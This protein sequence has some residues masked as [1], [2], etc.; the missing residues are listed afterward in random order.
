M[1]NETSFTLTYRMSQTYSFELFR[2]KERD[3]PIEVLE[4]TSPVVTFGWEPK[5]HRFCLVH[6]EPPRVD[7][8]FYTMQKEGKA[9][10]QLLKTLEK[11]PV[12]EIYWSPAGHN[13]VLAGMKTLNG[14]L[15]FYNADDHEILGEDE[16]F[17][18]TD[19]VWD[20]TGRFVATYVSAFRQP[21][22]NGYVIWNFAGK[23]Q[24]RVA[25]DKFF[26]FLWRPRPPS[27]LTPA[28][29]KEIRRKLPEYSAKY[30]EE[31]RAARELAATVLILSPTP[32]TRN[33]KPFTPTPRP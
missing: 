15:L 18:C 7:C 27:L 8:S 17:M 28:Q 22:E 31:D 1:A 5:G 19:I 2:L 30:L 6:G 29:E 25:K 11:K 9:Q 20:P 32:Y 12:N 23:V 10:V 24:V 16:H 3:V 26:Q 21:M 33:P 14:Q 4:I 13:V